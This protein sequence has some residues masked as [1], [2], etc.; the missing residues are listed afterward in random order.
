M[1]FC[2]CIFVDIGHININANLQ[3]VDRRD[4]AA[5]QSVE[6]KLLGYNPPGG[7]ASEAQVLFIHLS[8]FKR[9]N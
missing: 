8:D 7:L 2:N 4:A 6:R 3:N 9:W 1:W 5:I